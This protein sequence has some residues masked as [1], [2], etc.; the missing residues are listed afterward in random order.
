MKNLLVFVYALLCY[1][2]GMGGLVLFILYQG[3]L[4]IPHT[5]NS[6]ASVALQAGLLMNIML[7]LL[8]GVQH[9][10]M[11]RPGFKAILT[12][13][14]PT[15]AERSTYS[16]GSGLC[17]LAIVLWWQGNTTVVW[18][19]AGMEMPLRALSLIGWTITVWATFE[20]D[21]FDLFGLKE[22][23]ANLTGR[24]YK[25]RDFVTPFLYR[26][27]RH[28]I[29]TGVLVGMWPQA[30][31]T[32]GQ[33]LLTVTMTLYVF[34]GLYFEEKDLVKRFGER[35]LNYMKQVPRLFPRPGK[36]AQD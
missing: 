19:F 23:F 17:L 5:V 18:Q 29:Q 25:Q 2:I 12:K 34:V 26:Y 11:A 3:D 8:W 22:P 16:L 15:A 7:M 33:L 27:M 6:G 14:I 24:N 10:V 20:I 31:M 32:Q 35:Y 21:H 28:P 36:R 1:A 30:L 13:L 9:S 4:L